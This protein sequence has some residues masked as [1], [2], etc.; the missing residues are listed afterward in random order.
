M[1][2]FKNNNLPSKQD[3]IDRAFDPKNNIT[4]ILFLFPPTSIGNY[5]HR[6]GKEDLGDLKGDLI[7][8]GIAA[9]A[10]YLRQ[11]NFG[12]GALDCVALNI[13]HDEIVDI[14]KKKKTKV[15]CYFCNNICVTS[16]NKVIRKIKERISRFINNSWRITRKCS[17]HG[18]SQKYSLC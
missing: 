11:Y 7:P 3:L 14:I 13:S 5:S 17:R 12:V 16:F 2:F 4:D 10:A 15:S 8:L 1:F 6:Y 18:C 9:L